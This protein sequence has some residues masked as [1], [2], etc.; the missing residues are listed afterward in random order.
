MGLRGL[1]IED[2]PS[3]VVVQKMIFE[4]EGFEIVEYPFLPERKE[5]LYSELIKLKPDFLLIDHELNKRVSY[6]GY[7][8]LKEIRKSDSTIYAV[9]LTNFP[10]ED[11]KGEFGSYDLEVNKSELCDDDKLKDISEKI[12]RACDRNLEL[13]MLARASQAQKNE[14]EKLRLLTD[15]YNAVKQD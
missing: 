4:Q 2:D 13:E 10:K 9:L 11:F 7:D 6:T 12:R 8:A 5:D 3:N 14:E 1:Y 15:I